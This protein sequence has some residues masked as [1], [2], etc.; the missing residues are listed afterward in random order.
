[1]KKGTPEQEKKYQKEIIRRRTIDKL[2]T[3]VKHNCIDYG[4]RATELQLDFL[5]LNPNTILPERKLNY[6]DTL[7]SF[8]RGINLFIES[9]KKY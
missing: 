7:I 2:A 8:E 6:S 9:L 1:M 4:L 5:K 3:R